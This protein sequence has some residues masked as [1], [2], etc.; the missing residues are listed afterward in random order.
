[1]ANE[2]LE[3]YKSD[4][5]INADKGLGENRDQNELQKHF[6]RGI[7]MTEEFMENKG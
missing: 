4:K 3:M 6:Q 5:Y 2:K 7:L 1:M